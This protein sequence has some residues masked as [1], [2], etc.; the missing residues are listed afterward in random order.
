MIL[1]LVPGEIM[2]RLSSDCQLVST[3]VSTNVNLFLR[4]M[5]MMIGSL[6][7]MWVLSWRLTLV[8]FIII[9]PLGFFIKLYGVFYDVG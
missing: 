2:S 8:T 3:I 1:M 7:F 5:L 9:P 4:S 6:I